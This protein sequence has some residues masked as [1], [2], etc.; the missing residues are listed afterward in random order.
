L[1][2]GGGTRRALG[3]QRH[4]PGLRGR[5]QQGQQL[6]LHFEY[7]ARRALRDQRDEAHELQRVAETLLGVNQQRTFRDRFAVPTRQRLDH[8]LR[9]GLQAPFVLRSPRAK[10]RCASHASARFICA[11]A[12]SGRRRS[13]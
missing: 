6:R 7:D 8:R 2:I 3:D 4:A 5:G 10:S 1:Q 9:H 11:E 12:R 13:A